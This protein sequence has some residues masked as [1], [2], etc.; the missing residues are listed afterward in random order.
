MEY[1]FGNNKICR[2]IAKGRFDISLHTERDMIINLC[3]DDKIVARADV[4]RQGMKN[5]WRI[6]HKRSFGEVT[7]EEVDWKGLREELRQVVC[8][9]LNGGGDREVVREWVKDLGLDDNYVDEMMIELKL[10][11]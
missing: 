7:D 4:E 9:L 5:F 1:R 6:I 8:R 10:L 11:Q 2:I 3:V